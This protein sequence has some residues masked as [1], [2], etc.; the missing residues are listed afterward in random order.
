MMPV[1]SSTGIHTRLAKSSG[2]TREDAASD[3]RNGEYRAN[4]PEFVGRRRGDNQDQDADH[5]DARVEA[6]EQAVRL[7]KIF[8][9]QRV[10]HGAEKTGESALKKVHSV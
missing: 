9:V 5:F 1:K 8:G 10:L 3:E 4:H 2:E 6:L 7:G